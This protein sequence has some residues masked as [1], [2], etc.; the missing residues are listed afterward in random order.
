M[1]QNKGRIIVGSDHAGFKLKQALREYLV[2]SGFK[3]NDIGTYSAESCDYPRIAYNLAEQVSK[4]RFDRG[5]LICK[6]GIGTSIVANRL[7]GVRASLCYN[8]RVARLSRQHN[9]SNL[10]VLG[11]GFV[12]PFLAKRITAT[13][14]KTGFLGG[15]HRRRVNQI[16]DI[17]ERIANRKYKR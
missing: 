4:G 1:S 6:T 14:L 15:R 10:L 2:K 16:R 5:I 17:E 13:W 12:K 7:P 8:I 9:H 11:A 3:V